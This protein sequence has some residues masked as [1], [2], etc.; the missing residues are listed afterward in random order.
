VYITQLRHPFT[1]APSYFKHFCGKE[2]LNITEQKDIPPYVT[3]LHNTSQYEK[4]VSMTKC[5]KLGPPISLTRN[6][7]A[8]ALGYPH[9]NTNNVIDFKI[10]LEKMDKELFHVSILEE[11][12]ASLLLLKRK[13]CWDI[14]DIFHASLHVQPHADKSQI[15]DAERLW[16]MEAH[17]QWSTLDYILYDHYLTKL[18]SQINSQSQ[19]FA[20]DLSHFSWLENEFIKFC[21][22][23]CNDMKKI[24]GHN[25]HTIQQKLQTS[26]Q[27]VSPLCGGSCKVTYRDCVMQ[28]AAE[29]EVKMVLN[30]QQ[31]PGT[32]GN[33]QVGERLVIPL[34]NCDKRTDVIP[35]MHV[36]YL[37]D[38]VFDTEH[39]YRTFPSDDYMD[40]GT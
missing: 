29:H 20:Q 24:I 15:D 3:F 37:T 34:K 30:H 26:K 33:K 25:I 6:T 38:L 7:Q 19:D 40:L 1:N 13:L 23:M 5:G 9:P 21:Q 35:G 27:I 10:F 14:E 22:Q 17:Q 31:Y 4:L 8:L 11:F 32:C 12:E 28:G 39:C 16:R 2:R 36:T 18:H